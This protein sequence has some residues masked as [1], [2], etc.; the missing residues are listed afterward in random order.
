M[1][2]VLPACCHSVSDAWPWHDPLPGAEWVSLRF[3]KQRVAA[4]DF[5]H[6]GIPAPENIQRA[7]P[8]R[9][10]EYLAGRLCAREALRH[11]TG[12]PRV[13]TIAASRAP[14][15]PAGVAGSITHS[16]DLAAAL[17]APVTH[18]RGI[19]LDAEEILGVPRATRLASQILTPGERDWLTTLPAE[20]H[21]QF[22]TLVFSLK[23]SLFKALFPLVGV[24]FYFQD[25]EL[26]AWDSEMQRASLQLLKP[27]AAGWPAGRHFSG[28]YAHR[29]RHLLSMLTIPA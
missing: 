20:Q 18:Y 29:E 10:A 23:E 19:G 21:G 13:P 28:Q 4:E 5:L 8:K 14:L 3:D 1:S 6:C 11:L 25:A 12:I 17:V 9:Q 26:S 27:L 22:V 7:A 16:G 24:R 15:W 2:L